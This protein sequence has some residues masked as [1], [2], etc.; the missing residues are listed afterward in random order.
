MAV[1]QVDQVGTACLWLS[2]GG[3]CWCDAWWGEVE[4]DICDNMMPCGKVEKVEKKDD[5]QVQP[6]KD[7]DV[8]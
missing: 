3:A 4:E 7:I 5:P 2:G 1:D 6:R 8:S